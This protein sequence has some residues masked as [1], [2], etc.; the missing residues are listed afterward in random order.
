MVFISHTDRAV[1]DEQFTTRLVEAL[2]ADGIPYW[3]DREHPLGSEDEVPSG[4]PGTVSGLAHAR[5]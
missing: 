4:G 3:I 5:R 2:R 1:E